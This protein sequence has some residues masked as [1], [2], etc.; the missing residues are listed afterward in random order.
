MIL[1][2]RGLPVP[3]TMDLVRKAVRWRPHMPGLA[4]AGEPGRCYFLRVRARCNG[5]SDPGPA[6][7]LS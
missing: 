5:A 2:G 1:A 6:A 4:V 7:F 3:V